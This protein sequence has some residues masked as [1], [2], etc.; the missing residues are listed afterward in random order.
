M[1]LTTLA[2]VGVGI[3]AL[4]LV[5]GAATLPAA[6]DPSNPSTTFGKLVG[7]G[8][9][10]TQDVMN[11]IANAL[12]GPSSNPIIASY[13]ATIHAA[14]TTRAGGLPI[15]RPNG[16]GDGA[17]ALLTSIGQSGSAAWKTYVATGTPTQ[18]EPANDFQ[19][20]Q[21]DFARSSS[22]AGANAIAGGVLTY[23]PFATD[24]LDY[25]VDANSK[26]KAFSNG[27]TVQQIKDIYNGAVNE[28]ITGT[29]EDDPKLVDS[30]TDAPYTLA[31]DEVA[32]PIH[33]Y[34][35]QAGSGTRKFWLGTFTGITDNSSN[36]D[37]FTT[38]PISDVEVTG[39]YGI[40]EANVLSNPTDPTSTTPVE[41]HDGS[42]L[43]GDEGAITPFSIGK[44]V[45][46]NNG[47]A[48]DNTHGAILGTIDDAGTGVS[49]TNEASGV[50]SL[51][52]DY[53]SDF[54]A[55]N[56]T[57]LVYNIIPT[58]EIADKSSVTR[59]AFVGPNSLV[60][61][62]GS[63]ISEYGFQPLSLSSSAGVNECGDTSR[64]AFAASTATV[65]VTPSVTTLGYGGFYNATATVTSVGNG[66]GTVDFKIGDRVV[67]TEVVPAG[68]TTDSHETVTATGL[69]ATGFAP[70]TWSLT[71]VFH[72]TLEG[73]QEGA[74]SPASTFTVTKLASTVSVIDPSL[75][76]KVAPVI[77]VTV[78]APG[79]IVPTGVVSIKTSSKT[80]K[81]KVALVDGQVSIT[82]PKYS[83]KGKH[84]LYVEYY[85]DANVNPTTSFKFTYTAS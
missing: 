19:T 56:L 27:L 9:D 65:S 15:D 12:G 53:V 57:R 30:T 7:V 61:Q 36:V 17:A 44:W 49:P 11:G 1:R 81:S 82:L 76:H 37:H 41:E 20:G 2:K 75:S 54:S 34:V 79:G 67:D 59:W 55:S 28:I 21:V 64:T 58:R 48:T 66:G 51:N 6:A 23:V 38:S 32:T 63:V 24:A 78:T 5:A 43:V 42:V 77:N 45:A 68:A 62:E 13:D 22:G 80:L 18:L 73:V 25:A 16:S 72:P 71:A 33:V 69:S 3:T 40:D 46:D 84:T 26:F 35:P 60:C 8:S 74:T 29:Q 70:G 14:I 83:A 31:G 39:T 85:G 52:N 50:Y 4:A 47:L 10:T